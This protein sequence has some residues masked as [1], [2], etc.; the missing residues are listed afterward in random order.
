MIFAFSTSKDDA[1]QKIH[2]IM[3]N[4][5]HIEHV[6]QDYQDNVL[7]LK[8]DIEKIAGPDAAFAYASSI[9]AIDGLSMNLRAGKRYI[10][11]L[12]AGIPWFPH[13]WS[14]DELISLHALVLEH[15]NDYSKDVLMRYLAEIQGDG[16][17]PNRYPATALGNADSIGWLFKRLHDYLLLCESRNN[18]DTYFSLYDLKYIRERLN[19]SIRM[20]LK[21]HSND[22]L[23]INKELETWIDTYYAGPAYNADYREG[24]RIEIQALFLGMLKLM[25]LLDYYLAN[26]FVKKSDKLVSIIKNDVDY[27]KL[28]EDT[29]A[30]V[31][32]KF[33]NAERGVL[34]DGYACN[35][36]DVF[37]PNVFLAYYLYPELLMPAEW[38]RA[39]DNILP[40]LWCEWDIDGKSGGGLATI[41]K[42]YPLYQPHYTGL[43]NKSYHRGDSW[44]WINNIAAISMYRLDKHRYK[45]YIDK[46]LNA[47]TQD[48]LFYGFIGH[49]SEI[50]S[51]SI[52][53]PAGC[54]AQAWSISTYIELIHEM[55]MG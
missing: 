47:S 52:F 42:A 48:I 22:G 38:G 55:Y 8:Y 19:F 50:T 49:A 26:R 33:Y 36:H 28:E 15:H 27:K 20:L 32:G 43:D 14:R 45:Q 51:S 7:S 1:L 39:F 23:I 13:Y 24:A 37:R 41:D 30:L 40:R 9:H 12:W 46:I 10:K 31:R 17:L 44:F 21:N 4:I 18:F 35:M 2:D 11:G 34:N 54:L 6:Y 29:R 53:R 3:E 5:G 16:R 25:N